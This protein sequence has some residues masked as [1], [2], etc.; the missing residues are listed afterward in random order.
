ML[1]TVLFFIQC[2]WLFSGHHLLLASY[3]AHFLLGSVSKRWLL[4]ETVENVNNVPACMC[5]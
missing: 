2:A 5:G 4:L 3:R 1:F